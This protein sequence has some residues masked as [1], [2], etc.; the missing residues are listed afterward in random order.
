MPV[1]FTFGEMNNNYVI[2]DHHTPIVNTVC[3][4][5]ANV[6]PERTTLWQTSAARQ[7]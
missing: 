2:P 4:L 1:S 7:H 3:A 6:E 5:T